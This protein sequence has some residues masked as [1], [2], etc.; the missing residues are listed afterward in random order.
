[1]LET[2]ALTL[3]G[4]ITT[5]H[6]KLEELKAT[7]KKVKVTEE[8]YQY[9]FNNPLHLPEHEKAVKDSNALVMSHFTQASESINA[10]IT[11]IQLFQKAMDDHL[12]SLAKYEKLPDLFNTIKIAGQRF[13]DHHNLAHSNSEVDV[14]DDGVIIV[15]EAPGNTILSLDMRDDFELFEALLNEEDKQ[16]RVTLIHDRIKGLFIE[17]VNDFDVDDEFDELWSS[18]FSSH[19][20]LSAREFIDILSSDQTF[21]EE[22]SQEIKKENHR[23]KPMV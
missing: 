14:C 15:V 11:S 1:M 17:A 21:F 22:V 10:A 6:A 5:H 7:T 2:Q 19:N 13:I 20:N 23:A 8:K 12:A 3:V 9:L 18:D 4:L 16:K